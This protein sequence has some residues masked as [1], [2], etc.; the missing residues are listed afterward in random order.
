MDRRWVEMAAQVVKQEFVDEDGRELP[1][2]VRRQIARQ[3]A[4]AELRRVRALSKEE[5]RG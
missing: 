1:R 4:K 3:L 2:K 5:K